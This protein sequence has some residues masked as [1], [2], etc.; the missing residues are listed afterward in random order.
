V[1][2]FG[3]SS[4]I[5]QIFVWQISTPR[6]AGNDPSLGP[7]ERWNGRFGL[8]SARHPTQMAFI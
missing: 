8:P 3:P 6:L 2:G 1:N 5:L 4:G 7:S